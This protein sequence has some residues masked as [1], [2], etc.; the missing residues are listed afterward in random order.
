MTGTFPILWTQLTGGDTLNTRSYQS[1]Y[2]SG[3]S[4]KTNWES[5]VQQTCDYFKFAN[6]DALWL[7][8][9]YYEILTNDQ[10]YLLS[11]RTVDIKGEN[12]VYFGTAR[13]WAD[14]LESN[15]YNVRNGSSYSG[16]GFITW[17]ARPMVWL[18]HSSYDIRKG[19]NEQ[20]DFYITP[21]TE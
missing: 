18:P 7:N 15:Q 1:N 5:K 9:M 6:G 3:T 8:N 11:T 4:Q 17:N 19:E 14:K 13:V 21:K 2:I 12:D 16:W 10:G 20:F